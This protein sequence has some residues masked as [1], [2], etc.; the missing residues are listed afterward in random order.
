[1]ISD[2]CDELNRQ[3]KILSLRG[4]QVIPYDYLVFTPGLSY[5]PEQLDTKLGGIVGIYGANV[6]DRQAISSCLKTLNPQQH[7][8][9]YGKSLQAYS[10]IQFVL[11]SG[12]APKSIVWMGLSHQS[13]FL[14]PNV[15]P[16]VEN[17]MKKLGINIYDGYILDEWTTTGTITRKVDTMTLV[18]PH[19]NTVSK[20]HVGLFLCADQKS[21]DSDIF[22]TLNES[23]LVFD[24]SLVIDKFFRTND[25]A[26][27]A[28]GSVTKYASSFATKWTHKQYDNREVG[29]VLAE[30]LIPVFDPT[31]PGPSFENPEQLLVFN[32]PKKVY[33]ELPG[34][35]YLHID[36]PRLEHPTRAER[37]QGPDYVR[38]FDHRVKI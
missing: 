37:R 21:V 34:L 15:D 27:L 7:V 1:M 24:G 18:N 10:A 30:Q 31:S 4:G 32:Q 38:F 20:L 19:T 3:R 9:I 28:A 13:C 23:C 8:I 26:I 36:R 25:P 35:Y 33:V 5:Q 12:V 6:E 22:K 2:T 29:E 14:D 16:I 17:Q 11:N